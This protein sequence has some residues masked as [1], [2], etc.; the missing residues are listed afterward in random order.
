MIEFDSPKIVPNIHDWCFQ[1]I[2]FTGAEVGINECKLCHRKNL[3]LISGFSL[4]LLSSFL[5]QNLRHNLNG[6]KSD[7]C[8]A[9]P[10]QSLINSLLA[11]RSIVKN[12]YND[13]SKFYIFF[14]QNWYMDFLNFLHGFDKDF[15]FCWWFYKQ[16]QT[17]IWYR[18]W[19]SLIGLK[20]SK[21]LKS[22]ALGPLGFWQC[23]FILSY[24]HDFPW[25]SHFFLK[26][27][28]FLDF[29][30]LEGYFVFSWSFTLQK[31]LLVFSWSVLF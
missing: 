14:L 29:F 7:H 30:S 6:P 18:F 23:S 20:S 16:N 10:S 9:L 24:F 25:V 17:K 5:F 8:L 27:L 12:W 15:E 11:V 31:T 26:D 28:Y 21:S 13:F 22:N 2:L 1:C 3:P 19:S 4:F